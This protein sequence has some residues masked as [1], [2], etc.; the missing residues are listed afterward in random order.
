MNR[1]DGETSD[2]TDA[3]MQNGS[4]VFDS[5][6]D[7]GFRIRRGFGMRPEG[8]SSSAATVLI[9]LTWSFSG[10]GSAGGGSSSPDQPPAD[11][12]TH[13]PFQDAQHGAG[14]GRAQLRERNYF[15]LNRIGVYAPNKQQQADVTLQA[16]VVSPGGAL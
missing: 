12:L 3:L 15:L 13:N 8:S 1:W 10:H 7:S 11:G 9:F 5:V 14:P 4:T 16:G 2:E 6:L